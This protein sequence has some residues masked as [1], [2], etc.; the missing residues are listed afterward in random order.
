MHQTSAPPRHAAPRRAPAQPGTRA[1]TRSNRCA[2]RR[3]GGCRRRRGRHVRAGL[4]GGRIGDH[5]G[6]AA[7]AQQASPPRRTSSDGGLP[8]PAC[9]RKRSC[10]RGRKSRTTSSSNTPN[11][12]GSCTSTQPSLSPRS[13]ASRGEAVE[14]FV[15]VAQRASWLIARQLDGEAEI[16]RHAG[17]PARV[18][19]GLVRP[20]EGRIDFDGGK[21]GRIAF[22]VAALSGRRRPL[23]WDA[24]AGAADQAP[25]GEED[26]NSLIGTHLS[27]AKPGTR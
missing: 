10:R 15:D 25:T 27:G 6:D 9:S 13:P 16:V 23:P 12:G 5:A 22:E 24:P 21:H 7:L 4:A 19:A 20:V 18:G 2:A 14:Q 26:C 8:A 1:D 11:L 3:A 17:G